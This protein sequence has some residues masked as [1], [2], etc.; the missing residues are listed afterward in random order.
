M[1]EQLCCWLLKN[2]DR[3]VGANEKKIGRR[4]EK[5]YMYKWIAL[6]MFR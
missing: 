1:T 4:E 3:E 5:G 6:R 2:K